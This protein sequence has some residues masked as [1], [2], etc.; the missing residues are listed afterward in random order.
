[1]TLQDF[2]LDEDSIYRSRAFHELDWIDHGFGTKLSHGWLVA[3]PFADLDQIHSNKSIEALMPGR[4]GQGD[5]LFTNRPG[6]WIAVRTADCVPVLLAD[7]DHRAIAMIHAGWRG[8]A[9]G[10]IQR[11]LDALAARFGSRPGQMIAAIG[12]AIGGCC[13]EVGPEVA[14]RFP[15]QPPGK[16]K[17]DLRELLRG[18]LA[19]TGVAESNIF[20]GAPCT[21]CR[22]S[23]FFSFRREGAAAGRMWSAARIRG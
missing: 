20:G 18:Q 19:R 23:E 8:T 4:L 2:Y 9:A 6:H 10:I 11:T 15:G 13:Y 12:P 7:P 17:L 3:Q 5:A 1:L 16:G 22:D 14:S 21:F